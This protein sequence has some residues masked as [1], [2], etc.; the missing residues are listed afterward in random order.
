MS[1]FVPSRDAYILLGHPKLDGPRE[2][3][4]SKA[5]KNKA[6]GLLTGTVCSIWAPFAPSTQA[7]V[8]SFAPAY[9][10][11]SVKRFSFT[12]VCVSLSLLCPSVRLGTRDRAPSMRAIPRTIARS[13]PVFATSVDSSRFEN[14]K[15]AKSANP[16]LRHPLPRKTTL[17]FTALPAPCAANLAIVSAAFAARALSWHILSLT[18]TLPFLPFF[19]PSPLPAPF[20]THGD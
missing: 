9:I 4:F 7:R 15:S 12:C 18:I 14:A 8:C 5:L 20:H 16:P 11:P 10:N 19:L 17:H 2:S 1:L 3:P 6:V 13:P